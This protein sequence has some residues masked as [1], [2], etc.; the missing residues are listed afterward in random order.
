MYCECS[1]FDAKNDGIKESLLKKIKDSRINT[2]KRKVRMQMERQRDREMGG[3]FFFYFILE[4]YNLY[5]SI[6]LDNYVV[7]LMN[8]SSINFDFSI[9]QE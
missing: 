7:L 8:L 4:I 3:F 5:F 1:E 6:F 9:F 2:K